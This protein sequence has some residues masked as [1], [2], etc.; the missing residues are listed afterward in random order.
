[1]NQHVNHLMEREV[2][3]KEF[4]GMG[5]LAVVSIFGFGTVLKLLTGKSLTGNH[6]ANHGYGGSA[7]GK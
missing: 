1:M 3:R 2:S 7:Y 6:G 4:L 5:G